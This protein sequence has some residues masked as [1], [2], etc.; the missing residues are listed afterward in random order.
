MC[1]CV[2]VGV[3]ACG[4]GVGGPQLLYNYYLHNGN[5]HKSSK[6]TPAH[7]PPLSYRINNCAAA[8]LHKLGMVKKGTVQC[9]C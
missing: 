1:V 7:V 5:R 6:S 4:L 9:S 2:C 3:G 8:N